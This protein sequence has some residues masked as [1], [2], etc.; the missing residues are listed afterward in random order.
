MFYLLLLAAAAGFGYFVYKNG[1]DATVAAVAAGV[2]AV[3]AYL[4]GFLD[5]LF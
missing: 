2:V 3:G 1:F 4:E 5:K